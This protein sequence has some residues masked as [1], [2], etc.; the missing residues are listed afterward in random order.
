MAP[1]DFGIVAT[2]VYTNHMDNFLGINF[3]DSYGLMLKLF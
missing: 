3:T 1:K 2:V